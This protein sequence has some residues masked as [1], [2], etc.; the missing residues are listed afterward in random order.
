MHRPNIMMHGLYINDAYLIIST[1][2]LKGQFTTQK[3]VLTNKS[4]GVWWISVLQ[5]KTS[6]K[7]C[8]SNLHS[9]ISTNS[10]KRCIVYARP[11]F[12]TVTLLVNST[13]GYVMTCYI[14]I[15]H[16][17]CTPC[18]ISVCRHCSVF[19]YKSQMTRRQISLIQ[20]Q[21]IRLDCF[22]ASVIVVFRL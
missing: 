15:A 2:S 14:N 21:W 9:H 12:G 19:R 8:Q 4:V 18:H 7:H 22:P 10:Q 17:Y 1:H 6:T 13:G 20:S 3:P 5:V 16:V 11:E